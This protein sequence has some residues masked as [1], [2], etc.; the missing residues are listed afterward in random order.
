MVGSSADRFKDIGP[1]DLPVGWNLVT[2]HEVN[3]LSVARVISV[4][5]YDSLDPNDLIGKVTF[6]FNSEKSGYPKSI[7]KS[8][9]GVTVVVTGEWY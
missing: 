1:N 6:D 5:D 4:Y 3:N 7:S 2:A 9:N 8:G